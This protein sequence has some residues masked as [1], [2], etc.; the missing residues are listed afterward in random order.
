[1]TNYYEQSTTDEVQPNNHSLESDED[2]GGTESMEPKSEDSQGDDIPVRWYENLESK[3]VV[4]LQDSQR[5]L[6]WIR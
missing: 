2:E 5:S 4:A 3:V 1:M 6:S